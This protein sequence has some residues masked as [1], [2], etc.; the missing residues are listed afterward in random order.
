MQIRY[1]HDG[2]T[3]VKRV[4]VDEGLQKREVDY[5]SLAEGKK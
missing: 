1:F 5:F 2:G 3:V 4:K